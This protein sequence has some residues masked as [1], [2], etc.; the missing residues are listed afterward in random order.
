MSGKRGPEA[1]VVLADERIVAD[2]IDVVLDD[3]QVALGVLRD[4]CRRRRC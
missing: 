2:Q 3:H 4:S 1:V